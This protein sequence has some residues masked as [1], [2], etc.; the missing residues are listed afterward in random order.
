MSAKRD[1][2]LDEA[3]ARLGR[4]DYAGG[5][6]SLKKLL[7]SRPADAEALYLLG[8]LRL[9]EDKAAEAASLMR[10]AIDCGLA[11]DPVVLE[12]LGT[13]CLMS[14][15]ATAAERE[16]RRAIAAGGT[17]SMLRMRLG[18][19]L[20]ALE[21]LDE[22]EAMLH[23]A[24]EQ[25][26]HD[27]DIAINLGNVLAARGFPDAALKEYSRV[28]VFAPGH[29]QVLFNIGTLHHEAGRFEEAITVYL[30]V[31][32][33][34]PDH[35]EAL[36]NLGTVHEHLGDTA[37]AE[38][39]YR[40]VWAVEP[41]NALALSNLASV[42]LTQSR[43]DEAALC[44]HR[45]LNLR[46]DFGNA[47][48]NLGGI[49][50]ALGELD[51]ARRAYYRAWQ[52]V[53]AD[54]EAR[55]WCGTLG[56]ALGEFSESWPHYQARV[57]RRD[58]LQAVGTLDDQLPDNISSATIL[59]VGEQGIGDELFFL[60][61]AGLLKAR[62]A[63]VL[64]VCNHKIR[65]L[66]ECTG[67]FDALY[68]HGEPLPERD[69]TIA[70]GDLPLVLERTLQTDG[71]YGIPLC[72]QPLP[73]RTAT[74]RSYLERLG[75]PPYLAVTWRSGTRLTE[76]ITWR[77]QFLSKEVPLDALASALQDFQG[78]IISLQ[79][80]PDAGETEQLAAMLGQPVHDGSALNAD[81]E[82]MLA[83]LGLVHEYVGVSNANMH[84][85]A[86]LGGRARV[87]VPNPPEWRWMATGD[88]SPWFPRFAVYRQNADRTWRQAMTQLRADLFRAAENDFDVAAR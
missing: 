48:V 59:L 72:L 8:A 37:E 22:A 84:L 76:Q 4:G 11:T 66:L 60:R 61:Y 38:R 21:R 75:P 19:A 83:L 18:M 47:L 88:V 52:I 23:A 1:A 82:D 24:Q 51:A 74:M 2:L 64:C 87:L 42:L 57:S 50:A 71:A 56:L 6:R 45:A 13:A 54:S 55:C 69:L 53:P 12:N 41:D 32:A 85:L 68:T 28:L 73:A 39:L 81:L 35:V 43:F 30:Q 34:A 46:P 5:E 77:D 33:I 20:V 86:G 31:L 65:A 79:R 9:Q 49:H 10:R 70:A 26:P 58:M 67:I 14:G 3:R 15:D 36:I 40:K 44:C 80:N 16:L 78:S 63:R 62:Q 17:R 29:V 25:D 27:V 7:R